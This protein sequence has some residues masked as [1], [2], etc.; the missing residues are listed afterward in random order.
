M[1]RVCGVVRCS[2]PNQE[3]AMPVEPKLAQVCQFI[4]L[5]YYF[6]LYFIYY[7]Y[8]FDKA[9]PVSAVTGKA[10]SLFSQILHPP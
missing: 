6:I 7:L 4:L 9:I 2:H 3:A 1:E 8:L 10:L 5:F